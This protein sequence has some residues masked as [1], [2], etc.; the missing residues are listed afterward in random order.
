MK[1]VDLSLK[2]DMRE[3]YE[4]QKATLTQVS[5]KFGF[6]VNTV[7]SYIVEVGGKIRPRGRQVGYQQTVTPRKAKAVESDLALDVEE[8]TVDN[9]GDSDEYLN[10]ME[11]DSSDVEYEDYN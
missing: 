7:K 8:D 2:N 4:G 11:Y 6:S 5:E 9:F 10:E 3:M 1:T